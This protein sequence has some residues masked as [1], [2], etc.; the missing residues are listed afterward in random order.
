MANKIFITGPHSIDKLKIAKLLVEKDDSLS[1]CK[2]FTSDS[3]Y[4]DITSEDYIYYLESQEI[5]LAYKNNVILFVNTENYISTGVSMD[6]YYNSDICVLSIKDFNN[7]SNTVFQSKL[8]D[9]LVIWIDSPIKENNSETRVDINESKYLLE[10][11]NSGIKY[12]YFLSESD[13]T[14]V[15]TI[16]EYLESDEER[17]AQI[18]EENS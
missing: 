1:I 13:E 18:L 7:I 17:K 9:I 6:N 8:N 14:I 3:S 12:L 10:R 5:D 11:L 4:K 15:D 2:K 16:F